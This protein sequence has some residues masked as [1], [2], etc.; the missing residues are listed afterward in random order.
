MLRGKKIVLYVFLGIIVFAKVDVFAANISG[1]SDVLKEGDWAFG[2]EYNKAEDKEE[3]KQTR[4][5]NMEV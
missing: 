4:K 2:V 3:R 1:V 5:R